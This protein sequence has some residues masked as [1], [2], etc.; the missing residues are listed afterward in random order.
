MFPRP[1]LSL[2]VDEEDSPV[3]AAVQLCVRF[4][5]S[6]SIVLPSYGFNCGYNPRRTESGTFVVDDFKINQM[7]FSWPHATVAV[8]PR[9]GALLA[10][11]GPY[12][13]ARDQAPPET[14][15]PS[16]TVE[17]HEASLIAAS[18]DRSDR[19]PSVA[20]SL[21]AAAILVG[22]MDELKPLS[23]LGQGASGVVQRVLHLPSNCEFALKVSR[24]LF[25]FPLLFFVLF[26]FE[27]LI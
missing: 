25:V 23:N 7:G 17:V 8:P 22:D 9:N 4:F 2:V 24:Y 10:A 11:H 21:A 14:T 18:T 3:K 16:A 5:L 15:I 26:I 20:S 12:Q 27:F 1:S 6:D 13:P 19:P